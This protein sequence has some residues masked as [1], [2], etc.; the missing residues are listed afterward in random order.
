MADDDPMDD[1]RQD[2]LRRY[3]ET[4]RSAEDESEVITAASPLLERSAIYIG[5]IAVAVGIAM[6]WFGELDVIVSTRGQVVPENKIIP[7]QTRFTGT[8]A[9]IAVT[10][11]QSVEKGALVIRLAGARGA[12][13]LQAQESSLTVR[14]REAERRRGEI[15]A[16]ARLVSDFDMLDAADT[17][18]NIFGD[19][20]DKVMAVLM[21]ARQVARHERL[22]GPD[23][24]RIRGQAEA[25]IAAI[26]KTIAIRDEN[27]TRMR[28]E[29]KSLQV[30][31]AARKEQLKSIDVLIDRGFANRSRLIQARDAV[32]AVETAYNQQLERLDS[33]ALDTAQDRLAIV[34]KQLATER[35]TKSRDDAL[36]EARRELESKKLAAAVALS[37][38]KEKLRDLELE[39]AK[40][41]DQLRLSLEAQSGL[42]IRASATGMVNGLKY[43]SPG[44]HVIEGEQLASIVP[45]GGRNILRASIPNRDAG[46][47]RP[48]QRA[49]VK[50]DAFPFYRFGTVPARVSSIFPEPDQ[51]SFAVLLLLERP[52]IPVGGRSERIA[53]GLDATVEI[54]TERRS[55]FD[56]LLD[57]GQ[58]AFS[59]EPVEKRPR[60]GA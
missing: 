36:A 19:A 49:I 60:G 38:R 40:A 55:L 23:F 11:G 17:D 14:T 13:D 47:I 54:V 24:D 20:V 30:T 6:L 34:T 58:Q 43:A 42:E 59:S 15:A 41:T 53:A 31:L 12:A 29:L 10:L 33:L 48:G 26:E 52:T 4:R 46:R 56:L 28:A 35:E 5:A 21:S 8:I 3:S 39:I 16:L 51:G 7:V 27:R 32:F 1:G 50:L 18:F 45:M 22:V 9:E 2:A 25:Q 57:R 44:Q 37:E